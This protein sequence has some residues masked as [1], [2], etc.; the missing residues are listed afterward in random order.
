MNAKTEKLRF[1]IGQYQKPDNLDKEQLTMYIQLLKDFPKQL[2]EE[3]MVMNAAQLAKPYRK[4]G[5]TALQVVHHLADSHMNAYIRCK[6]ALTEDTPVIKP[7]DETRWA[8]LEDGRCAPVEL[9]VALVEGIHERWCIL[10]QSLSEADFTKS[11]YHPEHKREISIAEML[12]MYTWHSAHHLSHI[13]IS[14][15]AK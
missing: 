13:E 2:R 10:L 7:Y 9:S 1:P 12:A 14:A 4:H 8:N 15:K 5:W 11:F 3:V 6:L